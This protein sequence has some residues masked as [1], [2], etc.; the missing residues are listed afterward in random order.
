MVKTIGIIGHGHFGQF[1]EMLAELF[2]PEAQIRIYSRRATPDR[3]RFFSLE[4]AASSDVV[5]LCGAI[6]EY[7]AQLKAVL[8]YLSEQSVVVD[9]AT[10]KSHTEA[11][12]AS[13]LGDR[14][15]LCLH[16]MFGP[17]SFQKRDGDVAG[18]RIVATANTLSAGTFE[19]VRDWLTSLG[20]LVVQMTSEE[21]DKLLAHTLFLTHYISYSLLPARF[22][23]TPID[24]LSVA[25]LMDAV[26]SVKNDRQLF[27]DV[28]RFNPYCREVAERFHTAQEEVWQSI[29]T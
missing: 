8:P 18:M 23:R 6:S 4:A 9:V 5:I 29:Q 7:E 17:E 2:V 28:Y 1:L 16:P 13:V 14:K 19:V 20:F 22:T 24:T 12:C 21:H 11:L 25:S 27:E 10:V 15:Y 3:E 26:E